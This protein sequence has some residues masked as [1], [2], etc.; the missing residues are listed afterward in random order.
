MI[1]N[2]LN[3]FHKNYFNMD[4][5]ECFEEAMK[6]NAETQEKRKSLYLGEKYNQEF[7]NTFKR[8]K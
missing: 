3:N 4:S 8:N 7:G 5:T 6:I 1:Y 2:I